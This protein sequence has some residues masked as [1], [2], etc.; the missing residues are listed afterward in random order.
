MFD[1]YSEGQGHYSEEEEKHDRWKEASLWSILFLFFIAIVIFTLVKNVNEQILKYNGNSIT[2]KYTPYV[3]HIQYI[4]ENGVRYYFN[5]DGGTSHTDNQITLYYYGDNPADAKPLT[6][7]WIFVSV[8]TFFGGLSGI[9]LWRL[10]KNLLQ[11]HH[12]TG[13]KVEYT[14]KS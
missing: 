7:V 4:D 6:W 9:C 3:D 13:E 12:Y 1:G 8:Y 10:L 5:I 14:Y 11:T 2:A